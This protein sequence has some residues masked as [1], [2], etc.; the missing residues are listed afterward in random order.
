M[1]ALPSWLPGCVVGA[2]GCPRTL[3]SR[4]SVV[5]AMVVLPENAQG[6][7]LWGTWGKF[8]SSRLAVLSQLRDASSVQQWPE[9]NYVLG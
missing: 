3:R 6:R 9:E 4:S 7:I 1:G 8:N 5:A 2:A